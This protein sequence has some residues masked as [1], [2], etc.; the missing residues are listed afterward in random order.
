MLVGV[1]VLLGWLLLGGRALLHEVFPAM[2]A[3]CLV[4][5]VVAR[6]TPPALESWPGES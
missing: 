3:S 6:L 5:V 1:V 4:Y 2:L